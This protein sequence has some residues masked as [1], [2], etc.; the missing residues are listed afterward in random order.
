M[1]DRPNENPDFEAGFKKGL[2][3]GLNKAEKH[4]RA[5]R[6]KE[7]DLKSIHLRYKS[8][9][10]GLKGMLDK[11]KRFIPKEMWIEAIHGDAG[12]QQ[13]REQ[14]ASVDPKIEDGNSK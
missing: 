1:R 4:K 7:A 6:N 11:V 9:V 10:G 2:T 12:L 13:W 3:Y 8:E 5:T 14:L